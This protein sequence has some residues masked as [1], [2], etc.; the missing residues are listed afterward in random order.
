MAGQQRYYGGVT[1]QIVDPLLVLREPLRIEAERLVGRI[2]TVADSSTH[3]VGHLLETTQSAGT[4][5][6]AHPEIFQPVREV[7]CPH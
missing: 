3:E 5:T 2:Y 7:Y 4:R 6:V 1:D